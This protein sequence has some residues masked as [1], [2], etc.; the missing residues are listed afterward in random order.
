M[1]YA[2]Q[3]ISII[4]HLPSRIVSIMTYRIGS[5]IDGIPFH[6]RRRFFFQTVSIRQ[7]H[8]HLFFLEHAGEL[9]VIVLRG[10][11]SP[12]T[13]MHSKPWTRVRSVRITKEL[14]YGKDQGRTRPTKPPNSLPLDHS[15]L[16]V[17]GSQ[18][19]CPGELPSACFILKSLHC[20]L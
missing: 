8:Q 5:R 1:N 3:S 9:R 16:E 19:F 4:K 12:I 18:P 2:Q 6:S 20:L 15:Q 14:L 13:N 11:N 7:Q 10:K 17:E